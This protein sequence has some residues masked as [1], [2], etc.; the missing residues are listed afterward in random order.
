MVYSV[1]YILLA[2]FGL[3]ILIFIHELG[4]YFMARRVGMKVEAFGIGFG[5]P[6]YSWEHKG[7]KWNLC[8][9]PFGGYVRIAGMEKQGDLEP[10]QIP[11]GFYGKRP[12]DRIKVALMG[13]V[14]NIVFAFLAFTL[15]WATGGRQKPFSEF[16]HLIGWLDV[17]SKLYNQTG[18]RPGDEV[19][20]LGGRPF[21]GFKD[22]IYQAVLEGK[23]GEIKGYRIDYETKLKT[24]F[25]YIP[26]PVKAGE[27][28]L[29]MYGIMSPASY[30]IYDRYPS[31]AELPLPDGSPMEKS[32]IQYKDQIVWVDGQL[33]FSQPQLVALINEPKALLTVERG[34]ERFLA[35]TP[36]LKISDLRLG[37]SV[38]AELDDWRHEGNI[39]AKV[40]DLFFIPYNLT[41]EGLVEQ[42]LPYIDE[43]SEEHLFFQKKEEDLGR[44][45]EKGD[46]I[47]AV[48]GIPVASSVDLLVKLQERRV[49]IIVRRG[50]DSRASISWKEAD[51][52]FI[53]TF[54]WDDISRIA[55]SI[56]SGQP[57]SSSGSFVL[58]APVTPK[59]LVDFPL[60]PEKKEKKAQELSAQKKEIEKMSSPEQQASALRL[61]EG[62]QKRL[63]LGIPLQDGL[64]WYNP[65]PLTLFGDVFEEIWRTLAAL[66]RGYV[67]PKELA[68]PV[69]IL[70]VMHHGWT[71]GV[72][73][74]LFWMAA[75][76]LN[77]GILNLLPIPVLDGG[78][79]CISL[80][81][82]VRKKPLSAKVMERLILPF[83]VL[84]IG[85]FIYVTY[86]DLVRLL[87]RFF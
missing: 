41:H 50:V 17:Q 14:V 27:N 31:G 35:R 38:K 34:A 22:F 45:L 82:A 52:Q 48:D 79:I 49:Q 54:Q 56:G 73:E 53:N 37:G 47:V 68:G 33:V 70:Q 69:G 60:S 8:W 25:D 86:N 9:L 7:V 58:L 3:G 64:V 74:A 19:A 71:L 15:I 42:A 2:A 51:P 23:E 43:N 20:Q 84:L 28:A 66:I 78:H 63:M 13:P 12:R 57:L 46:R 67:S 16:S 18:V 29:Q 62:R 85:F 39:S 5:K 36:R 10:Y 44:S 1:L 6:I 32:G 75:I 72:K 55:Q 24:P 59:A 21:K 30:L 65:S 40:A 26:E 80:V 77:L 76:S 81:E 61:L 11:D 87:G 83:I 4:H